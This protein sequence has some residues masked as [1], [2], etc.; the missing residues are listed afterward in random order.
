MSQHKI[1]LRIVK[2]TS[3]TRKIPHNLNLARK[4]PPGAAGADAVAADAVAVDAAG[5]AAGAAA[6]AEAAVR[7]GAAVAGVRQKP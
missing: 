6:A 1:L 4:S 7:P 2:S 5:E 3:S